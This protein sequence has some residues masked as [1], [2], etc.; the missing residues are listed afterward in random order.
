M[1]GWYIPYPQEAQLNGVL[2]GRNY[3]HGYE[4]W[5]RIKGGP[6]VPY[7]QGDMIKDEC[8][9]GRCAALRIIHSIASDQTRKHSIRGTVQ[10]SGAFVQPRRQTENVHD[11]NDL[12]QCRIVQGP[13]HVMQVLVLVCHRIHLEC[14]VELLATPP[15]NR[16]LRAQVSIARE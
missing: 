14:L 11:E 1:I 4:V 6:Q 9:L 3:G 7:G 5:F 13:R 2:S 8:C 10:W 16:P 15:L 12:K